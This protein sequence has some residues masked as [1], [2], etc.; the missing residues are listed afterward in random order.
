MALGI[1]FP[2]P[3]STE[4]NPWGRSPLAA[5]LA[6]LCTTPEGSR[7]VPVSITACACHPTP[8]QAELPP[9]N[10]NTT[11]QMGQS[12]KGGS[13]IIPVAPGTGP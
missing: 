6:G 9:K 10:T 2:V 7:A 11:E 1:P 3:L 8:I 5:T 4:H 13:S 12:L